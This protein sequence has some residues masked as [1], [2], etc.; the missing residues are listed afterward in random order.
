MKTASN[1]NNN[2][3]YSPLQIL[4]DSI[5]CLNPLIF[6]V[7]KVIGAWDRQVFFAAQ[8]CPTTLIIQ[9]INSAECL[10]SVSAPDFALAV[11]IYS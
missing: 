10:L 7:R 6:Q 11:C 5:I 4:E 3:V 8:V 2:H 1:R 9:T